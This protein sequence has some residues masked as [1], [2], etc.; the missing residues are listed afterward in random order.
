MVIGMTKDNR[1][2]INQ[3]PQC[4]LCYVITKES[5]YEQKN[6]ERKC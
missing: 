3:N 1:L 2:Q 6:Y 4:E 5:T